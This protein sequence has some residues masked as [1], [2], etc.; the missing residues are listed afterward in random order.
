MSRQARRSPGALSRPL[1]W[2]I[3]AA[4][5][6]ALAAGALA[7]PAFGEGAATPRCATANLRLDFVPPV[8]AAA[9]HRFWNMTLR[10][11]GPT[12]CHLKGFPGVGLL[13]SHAGPINDSVVRVTG[14]KQRNV[15]LHA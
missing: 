6:L 15:V 7:A 4:W 2:S 5:A 14:F 3:G 11:V 1:V 9:G 10:N 13:D 12:S 8:D